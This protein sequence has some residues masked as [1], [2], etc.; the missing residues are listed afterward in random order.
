MQNKINLFESG[1][2]KIISELVEKRI[3]I[4]KQSE[5]FKEKYNMLST[6]IDKLEIE[7]KEKQ[8]KD[9]Q[10]ILKLFYETEEYYFAFAYSLGVKYGNDLKQI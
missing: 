4:L 8:K 7:L 6:K 10:D 2:Y 3:N 5:G 1:D 9:F